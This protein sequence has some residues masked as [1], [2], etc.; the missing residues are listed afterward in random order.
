[1]NEYHISYNKLKKP[2]RH[3]KDYKF[4]VTFNVIYLYSNVL[5][6]LVLSN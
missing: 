6:F 4:N 2:V 3:L 1:M 5:S